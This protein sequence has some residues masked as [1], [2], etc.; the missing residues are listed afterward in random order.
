MD[1][2]VRFQAIPTHLIRQQWPVILPGLSQIKQQNGEDWLPED[3][4]ASLVSGKST[5]YLFTKATG[6]FCGFAVL[7]IIMMPYAT[8]PWLNIWI[9]YATERDYGHYG[10]EVAKQVQAQAGLEKTVFSSP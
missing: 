8:N 7:E 6:E 2:L 4:Y 1:G 9:G 10:V 3:V 5:L